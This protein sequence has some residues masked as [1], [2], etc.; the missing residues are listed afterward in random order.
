MA[1]GNR[2]WSRAGRKPPPPLTALQQAKLAGA[3][4]AHQRGDLAT[5]TAVYAELLAVAPRNFDAL[6]LLGAAF[7]QRGQPAEGAR[8]IEQALSVDPNRAEAYSNLSRAYVELGRAADAVAACDRALALAPAMAAAWFNRGNALLALGRAE[9]AI[10]SYRQS[11]SI[12]PAYPDALNNLGTTLHAQREY[13]L[14]VEALDEAVRL[15]P[16]FAAAWN[17]R[18]LSLKEQGQLAEALAS[19]ERALRIDPNSADALNNLGTAL[20]EQ[21]RHA[22]AREIFARLVAIAPD[23]MYAQGNLLH[24]KLQCCDWSGHEAAVARVTGGVIERPRTDF[25]FSFLCVSGSAAAQLSCARNYTAD[26]Y[27]PRAG[28]GP[29]SSVRRNDRLKVAYVSGDFG[30]HAV[31]YLLAEVFEAHDR[32]RIETIGVSWGRHGDGPVRARME[33]ALERF[34]DITGSSDEAVAARLHD[35]NV[36]I[37]V[38]LTGIRAATAPGSSPAA[39]RPCRST[40][41]ACRPRWAPP[42]STT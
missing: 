26:Q 36:D 20:M 40:S 4:A 5:A 7:I 29:G 10:A 33:Q 8:R 35:L 23:Y 18:G 12:T 30:A 2:G 25:P 17:N 34:I 42:T 21:R 16:G 27:P 41:S 15:Q 1:A 9:D 13:A 39:P 37:A 3:I 28:A 31:S 19:Y 14:A 6:H 11:L 38:D 24:A 32:A 22:E